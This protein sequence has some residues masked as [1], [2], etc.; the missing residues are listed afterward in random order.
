MFVAPFLAVAAVLIAHGP[1][2]GPAVTDGSCSLTEADK[3]ANRKLD[4]L[5]F[6][7]RPTLPSN[8]R[9]LGNRGCYREAADATE[10]YLAYGPMGEP[11]QR[12]N[13]VFHMAQYTASAGDE[14]TAAKLV[15]M[16]RRPDLDA[17]YHIDW[18]S[19]V[20]GMRAFW[21]KDR[22]GLDRAMAALEARGT[23]GDAMN[24]RA[25]QSL[26]NCFDRPYEEAW[27]DKACEPA[28]PPV[29]P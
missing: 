24:L 18:N 5:N 6:D 20:D 13:M 16:A 23:Q 28:A 10:D 22:A 3:V 12:A 19:F 15:V 7:Q 4:F 2:P 17:S 8:A 1:P 11:G 9:A 14:A 29:K 25:L 26:S 27:S 21:V